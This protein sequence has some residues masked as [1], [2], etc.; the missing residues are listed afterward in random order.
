MKKS[1]LITSAIAGTIGLLA[2]VSTFAATST[3]TTSYTGSMRSFVQGFGEGH[4][5][6]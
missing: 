6:K 5:M 4:G 1:I 3:G 2:A